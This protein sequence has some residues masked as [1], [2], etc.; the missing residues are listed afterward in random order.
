MDEEAVAEALL[1]PLDRRPLVDAVGPQRCGHIFSRVNL[2][3][4]LADSP[5]P[6]CPLCARSS[7]SGTDAAGS[8]EMSADERDFRPAPQALSALLG[9][10]SQPGW[11]DA[12]DELIVKCPLGCD[13]TGPR[14]SLRPHLIRTCPAV[15]GR[16]RGRTV[17]RSASDQSSASDF[18]TP[19]PRAGPSRPARRPMFSTRAPSADKL[20]PHAHLGCTFVAQSTR[21]LDAH[22]HRCPALIGS[23]VDRARQHDRLPPDDDLQRRIDELEREVGAMRMHN[24]GPAAPIASRSSS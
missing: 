14:A 8:I 21:E 22:V 24:L 2:R 17:S 7:V 20:C 23:L 13:W 10:S 18:C 12:A 15:E 11:T 1:C 9:M 3:A 16:D 6:A 5:D 4:H 19:T